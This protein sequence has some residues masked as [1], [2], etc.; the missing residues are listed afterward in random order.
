M[1]QPAA[2]TTAPRHIAAIP[3]VTAIFPNVRMLLPFIVPI[4]KFPHSRK[5]YIVTFDEKKDWNVAPAVQQ[6]KALLRTVSGPQERHA[7]Y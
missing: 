3:V 2:V 5:S 1:P 6:K 4:A 7:C